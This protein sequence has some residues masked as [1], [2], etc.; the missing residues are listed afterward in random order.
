MQTKVSA[1]GKIGRASQQL[2][3][4]R[5]DSIGFTAILDSLVYKGIGNA[6]SNWALC[7]QDG[8]PADVTTKGISPASEPNTR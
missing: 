8:K 7:R 1:I 4:V 5:K 6:R 3:K 2:N